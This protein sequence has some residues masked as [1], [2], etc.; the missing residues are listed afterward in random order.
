MKKWMLYIGL[1]IWILVS[2]CGT[3]GRNTLFQTS[4][5]NA[6]LAGV[7]DGDISCRHLLRHGDFG[8]GTFDRL[9]G[10][11]VILEG[12]IYQI[13]VDG[14]VYKPNPNCKTPFATTCYFNPEKTISID[15]S[16]DYK[17]LET[18][19]DAAAPNQNLFCAIR[20]TGQFRSMRTRSV[21]AQK[22]PYPPLKE[23]TSKQPEFDMNNVFGTIVGFRCPP[24]VNGINVPGYHLHFI[25]GDRTSGGHVLSF[26]IMNGRCDIDILNQFFLRLPDSKD[27]AEID[28]SR[29]QNK[30]LKDVERGDNKPDAGDGK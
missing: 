9:E 11:M 8:I 28:L 24:Y 23:V 19:I 21:P 25:N 5:I 30:E 22:R 3:P 16:M 15:T 10:E 20:I 2:G 12:T 1:G 18:L 7:Y 29:D 26:E 4:T 13:K 27:F 14:K 6:L 17:R